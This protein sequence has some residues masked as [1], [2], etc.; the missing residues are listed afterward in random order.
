MYDKEKIIPGIII[1]LL[2]ATLPFWYTFVGGQPSVVPEPQISGPATQ[3]VE[4]KTY[5][6]NSHTD[7][8]NTWRNEV[9]RKGNRVYI[10]SDG[11]EYRI[12]LSNTCMDCHSNKTEFCD[13]CHNYL[14]IVPDCWNCHI[15]PEESK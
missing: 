12:S 2:L 10:A 3:C 1:F 7:L 6:R 8:L 5:M 9:V 13:A 4:P 14:Q 15:Q 11:K